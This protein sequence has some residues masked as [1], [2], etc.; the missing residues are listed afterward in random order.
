MSKTDVPSP[1]SLVVA[2]LE[3]ILDTGVLDVEDIARSSH[4]SRR[5]VARWRTRE[6]RVPR[7]SEERLLEIKSVVDLL[8]AAIRPEAA[9]LWIRSPNPD[10]GYAGRKTLRIDDNR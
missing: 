5:T 3:Q 10:L 6:R 8:D 7:D 9:R 1:H 4:T 2:I